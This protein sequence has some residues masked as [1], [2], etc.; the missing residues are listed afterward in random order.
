MIESNKWLKGL[1]ALVKGDEVEPEQV[2][3]IG[4]TV[5][6]AMITWLVRH[7]QDSGIPWLLRSS[8]STLIG[9]LERW[10]T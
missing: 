8:I 2:R 3:G 10:K 4:I 6:H 9:E 5:L 7:S 1:L